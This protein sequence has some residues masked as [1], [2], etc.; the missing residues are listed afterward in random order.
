MRLGGLHRLWIFLSGLYLCLVIAFVALTFPKPEDIPTLKR[1]T[2]SLA[3]SYSKKFSKE[4]IRRGFE[5]K[6]SSIWM[7]RGGVD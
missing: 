6:R 1:S 2:S 5:M 7:R 3:Q 4:R